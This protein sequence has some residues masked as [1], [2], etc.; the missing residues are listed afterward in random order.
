MKP[1]LELGYSIDGVEVGEMRRDEYSIIVNGRGRL[2]K[3]FF[4]VN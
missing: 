1:R 4:C 3:T 2:A